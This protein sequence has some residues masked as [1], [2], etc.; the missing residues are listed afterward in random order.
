MTD[1]RSRYRMH[2]RL[3]EVLGTSEAATLMEPL[4]PVDWTE[5]AT[6]RDLQQLEVATK[7][8]LDQLEVAT[9]RGLEQLHDKTRADLHEALSGQTRTFV[10][11]M[12]GAVSSATALAF[13]AARFA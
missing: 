12:L 5:L 13:A 1:D 11:A 3:E 6:K 4:P 7:R 2:Q 9:K 10:F 8:D